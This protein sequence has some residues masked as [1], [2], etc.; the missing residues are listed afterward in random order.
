MKPLDLKAVETISIKKSGSQASIKRSVTVSSKASKS[1]KQLRRDSL[2]SVKLG[3]SVNA[4][5]GN[6]DKNSHYSSDPDSKSAVSNK[7]L[8]SSQKMKLLADENSS[9]SPSRPRQD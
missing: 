4:S 2:K 9:P 6:L 8:P 7:E 3:L 5:Q 1:S